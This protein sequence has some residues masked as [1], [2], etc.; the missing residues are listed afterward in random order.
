MGYKITVLQHSYSIPS[1]I[2]VV[3]DYLYSHI[4]G[5]GYFKDG[6]LPYNPAHSYN[7]HIGPCLGYCR[8]LKPRGWQ[9]QGLFCC[10]TNFLESFTRIF[11]SNPLSLYGFLR[12]L[13]LSFAWPLR[14]KEEP[15]R[16]PLYCWLQQLLCLFKVFSSILFKVCDF[17]LIINGFYL[18]A[19]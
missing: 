19:L 12:G 15:P 2:Q 16:G 18:Y 14:R 8:H 13:K 17:K 9:V 10:G 11:E 5:A 1:P 3:G 6:L 7:N 4:I